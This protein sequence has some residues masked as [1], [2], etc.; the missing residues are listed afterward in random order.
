M[1][2]GSL[3]QRLGTALILGVAA[4]PQSAL[5]CAACFGKSD[6]AMAHGMNMGIFTLLLV[7][8]A[9]LVG[10]A[11]FGFF[12]ARRSSRLAAGGVSTGSTG[13]T[14][15]QLSQSISQPTP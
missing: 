15:T 9:V 11:S 8:V 14:S 6:D 3:Q 13:Q 4:L 10:V 5:A 7:I 2:L 12:L 1:N